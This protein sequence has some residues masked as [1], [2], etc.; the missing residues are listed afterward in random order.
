MS[1]LRYPEDF[2]PCGNQF[3]PGEC[4][5]TTGET[6][7]GTF[8]PNPPMAFK[9]DGHPV[10]LWKDYGMV[11]PELWTT[12]G[13]FGYVARLTADYAKNDRKR[14]SEEAFECDFTD[15]HALFAA[16]KEWAAKQ[17]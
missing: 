4:N 10:V 12:N 11:C 9:V 8:D 3:C 7:M 15:P 14:V 17:S 6:Y 1:K 2:C 16:L 5:Q 13:H